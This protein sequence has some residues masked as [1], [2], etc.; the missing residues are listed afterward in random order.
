MISKDLVV[1][2]LHPHAK[3]KLRWLES[4]KF[5]SLEK[6]KIYNAL[7]YELSFSPSRV[8]NKMKY[9]IITI[10]IIL[11]SRLS[12]MIAR[13]FPS[14]LQYKSDRIRYKTERFLHK[15]SGNETSYSPQ[16]IPFHEQRGNRIRS[17]R[18]IK[19]HLYLEYS[20]K[21]RCGSVSAFSGE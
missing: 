15:R 2:L 14:A 21:R 8:I 20:S 1:F 10:M 6:R 13:V 5:P 9:L 16:A 19:F 12:R 17:G 4:R 7:I 18:R 3:T 11:K